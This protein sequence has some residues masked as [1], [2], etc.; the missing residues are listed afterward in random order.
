MNRL[1]VL[2]VCLASAGAIAGYTHY[3][4]VRGEAPPVYTVPERAL[5][6][7]AKPAA[8]VAPPANVEPG[9][10]VALTRTLQRE[11][12]RVGCYHGE[13]T[14]VWTTSSRMAMKA[15]TERVNAT[16]PIDA[17]D[18]VLLSLVQGHRE[19]ACGVACPAGQTASESGVCV[20]A[21]VPT[22]PGAEA[23][24]APPADAAH[25]ATAAKPAPRAAP[26]KKAPGERTAAQG[27]P[28][29]PEGVRER[30]PRRAEKST[31]PR[32]PKMVQDM[33][34]AL[35]FKVESP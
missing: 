13:I 32:P 2:F 27:G 24:R 22:A 8:T 7:A 15:F 34:R 21:L 4:S 30:K 18:Q 29:P 16:L 20:A 31:T 5:E 26:E 25:S 3:S 11:L 9:D 1:V 17:P 23:K 19:Q 35:G 12:K 28:A 10:R 14:G 33:L 6:P